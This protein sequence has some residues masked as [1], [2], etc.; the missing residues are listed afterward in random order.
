MGNFM[1]ENPA[2]A[3]TVAKH[4][5]PISPDDI[6]VIDPDM[7]KKSVRA[8]AL[9]NIMEW[10]DFGVYSY[11]ATVI[12]NVFFAG[13]SPSLQLVATF[14]TFAAAFLVRP[15]GGMV[16]GPLGDLIGR[17]KVL[18]ITMIM[19]SVAT[20]CLGL[21]PSYN[22]IGA[23]APLLL[24]LV[25][26]VQG[27]ST[28]G[29]YGGAATFIAEYSPDKQRGF[30]GSFLEVGTITG[31]LLGALLVTLLNYL[32]STNSMLDWGWRLPFFV[33]APLGIFGLYIRLKLEET[34]AFQA[35]IEKQE[36]DEK[37]RGSRG[38]MALLGQNLGALAQCIGLVLL[39]NVSNYMLTAYMP[40]YLSDTLGLGDHASLLLVIVLMFIMLPMT[41]LCGRI[42]D[43]LGRRP[44]I[45]LG[46]A[47][48]IVL[49]YP[50]FLLITSHQIGLVF[51]GLLI[52]GILHGCFSGTM[53][54]TLPALFATD[55]R[56]SALAIGFNIS[57]SLFGGTTPLINAWLVEKTGN[58]M[59]PAFY[60][61]IAGVVGLV[62][63]WTVKES[64]KR[65]LQGSHPAVHTHAEAREMVKESR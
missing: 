19:M 7:H 16:F 45:A 26:L 5:T 39:F 46:A 9:G 32:L 47:G 55:I 60:M 49:S 42:T 63:I 3:A 34:P 22:S 18:A 62:T 28:G 41:A 8:A 56:Y 12:G 65:P 52:L 59:I 38:V 2:N 58:L 33:S 4:E 29:E 14:G 35:H 40:S 1:T 43:T 57:V 21:I 44:V 37:E 20:F 15:I 51:L 6:T 54:S 53:P 31:Y 48:L 24:L 17:Q 25:R 13:T 30:A 11:L 61:A 50:A 10:F 64:A 36:K 23:A 27:F